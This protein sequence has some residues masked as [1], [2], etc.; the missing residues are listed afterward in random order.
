MTNVKLVMGG[1]GAMHCHCYLKFIYRGEVTPTSPGPMACQLLKGA[2]LTSFKK[3]IFKASLN[4]VF[5]DTLHTSCLGWDIKCT[6]YFHPYSYTNGLLLCWCFCYLMGDHP[7]KCD[8]IN[9]SASASYTGV[10]KK[11]VS[12]LVYQM[13]SIYTVRFINN[14]ALVFCE[15]WISPNSKNV[16]R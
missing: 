10:K 2:G 6:F 5:W 4:D 15:K 3:N 8:N 14:C 7:C 9:M 11:Q 13:Y 1:S 12:F 16:F